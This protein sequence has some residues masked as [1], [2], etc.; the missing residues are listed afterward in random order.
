[1]NDTVL[2]CFATLEFVVHGSHTVSF[3]KLQNSNAVFVPS[4]I[5]IADHILAGA[6]PSQSSRTPS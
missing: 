6:G 2:D 4:L 1:M 5:A 3:S